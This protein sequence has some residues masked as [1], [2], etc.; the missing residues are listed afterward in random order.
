MRHIIKD[1]AEIFLNDK[2]NG[3]INVTSEMIRVGLKVYVDRLPTD[4]SR[5]G[6]EDETVRLIYLEMAKAAYFEDKQKI[7]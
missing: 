1:T 6:D 5:L 7:D 2:G 4:A 3:L